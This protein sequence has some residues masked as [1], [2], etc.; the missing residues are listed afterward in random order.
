MTNWKM[1]KKIT[2]LP[3]LFTLILASTSILSAQEVI[4][5]KTDRASETE[6]AV[7]KEHFKKYT[8]ATLPTETTCQLLRSKSAFEKLQIEVNGETFSFTLQARDIRPPHYKLRVFDGTKSYELPRTP[9]KTYFGYTTKGHY[10]VRITS[11]D[12]FFNALIVQE[13]DE[14]Y[15]ENANNIIPDAPTNQFVMYW[16][17]DNLRKFTDASCGVDAPPTHHHSKDIEPEIPDHNR[18]SVCKEVQIALADD[19]EM[20]QQEGSV[21]EVENHNMAVINNVETNYDDEFTTDLEFNIVE[22][23]VATS[24]GTDPWTNSTDPGDLLDDFTDWGPTGFDN[25]HDIGGLWTNRNFDGDVIGLAWVS[26]VCTQFRYHVLEDFTGN[27][28]L[29]RCLQAHEMGHAFSA[30]HDAAGSPHIMA[31]MVRRGFALAPVA[32]LFLLS[33]LSVRMNKKGAYPLQ[34]ILRMKATTIRQVG[35]GYFQVEVPEP[36]HLKIQLSHITAQANST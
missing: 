16:G 19:F 11:D 1:S 35:H 24:N 30:N 14:F 32:L 31:P 26:S 25:I 2:I 12:H 9:N 3:I 23:Y 27:A 6:H 18:L 7:Y 21:E 34:F 33:P 22:I 29:L 28:N 15:I 5:F 4:R 13:N 17:S 36:V 20:F 8:L 10:D